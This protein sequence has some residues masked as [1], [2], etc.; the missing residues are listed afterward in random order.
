MQEITRRTVLGGAVAGLAATSGCLGFVTGSQSLAFEADPAGVR[1]ETLSE[2]GYEE[3]ETSSPSMSREFTVAG[4]TREVEV[5]NH[6][7]LYEKAADLGPLGSQ[8]VALFAL[9][10]TPKVEIADRTL[11]PVDDL[12]TKQLLERFQSRYEG[13]SIGD[14]VGSETVQT[15]GTDVTVEKYEGSTTVQGQQV[16]IRLHVAR[17][18]H[19]DDFVVGVGSYPKR[20]DGEAENVRSLIGGI[21][22]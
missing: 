22:H 14:S 9:F 13:L 20:L 5:T 18:E 6:L 2:T 8:K 3:A 12:S 21:R 16:D 7:A 1:D 4:Q 10:T 11:N 19:G 17:F 15:L